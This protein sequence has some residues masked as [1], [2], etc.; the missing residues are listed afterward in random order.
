[1]VQEVRD[2][3]EEIN[4]MG[5]SILLVEHNLK[6]AMSLSHRLYLMA[7]AQVAFSGTVEELDAQPEI[8]AKY[9]EI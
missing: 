7:K 2:T 9:L 4:R 6:V 5:M 1:M 3:L 8:R